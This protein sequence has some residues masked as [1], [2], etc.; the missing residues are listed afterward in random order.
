MNI[1]KTH[2]RPRTSARPPS[3]LLAE[4]DHEMR[5][6]LSWALTRRGYKVAECADG[7]GLMR[8][9]GLLGPVDRVQPHDL[10]ISDIRMPG[11][12][13]LQV[14][15]SI[16][17]FSDFPP[18]ILIT[19]FPNTDS[20]KQA[21]RLGAVA[22]LAKPFDIEE[23]LS[24]IR[25]AIPYETL[26]RR[27]R[28]ERRA[29]GS[30]PPFPL[31]ITL[32]H[33]SGSDTARDYIR[34]IAAKLYAFAQYVVSAR[35]VVDQADGGHRKK[36]RYTVI[37]VLST[38]GGPVVA[39]HDTGKDPT[40]DDLYMAVN[41]VFGTALRKLKESVERRQEHRTHSTRDEVSQGG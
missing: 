24:A 8:K 4:D 7:T 39:K 11:V 21:M 32:R 20:R 37:L 30:Q 3:I 26:K 35:I 40:S 41:V 1:R 13:G 16:R 36:H 33:D 12:T 2:T 22:M 31:E 9:L 34:T 27:R 29:A 15:E 25:E 5:K 18:M 23:L 10:I 17:E 28:R 38:S 6:L 14:L 19:A